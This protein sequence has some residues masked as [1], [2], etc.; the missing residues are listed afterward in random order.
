ME[1]I[2]IAFDGF[3]TA[4]S[5]NELAVAAEQAGAR[6][7]WFAEHMGYREAVVSC[8][9][10]ALAT[11]EA[12]VVP[13]AISPYLWHPTPTAMSLATLAELAAGRV[14][15]ALGTGN[16]LFLK[17]SGKDVEHPV[18]AVSEFL[19]CLRNLWS[20]EPVHFK[21][22]FFTLE[23]ARCAF[24]PPQPIPIYIA[25]IGPK[26]L[27]L[28]GKK[29]DGLAISAGF[30]VPYTKLSLQRLRQGVEAAGR[31]PSEVKT[32][33]YLMT[34]VSDDAAE[35]RAIVREKLAFGLRN[36]YVK[37]NIEYTGID[38]DLAAIA[39]AISRRD[40]VAAAKLVPPEAIDAFT[41]AGTLEDC[42]R[43]LQ[44]YAGLG[45]DEIVIL[46]MGAARHQA[47]ALELIN[48]L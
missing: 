9:A 48:A 16:P 4:P 22:R 29:A 43:R 45:L 28:T 31:R 8:T 41:V 2:G 1:R 15:V 33:T 27:E 47:A 21:G 6:S 18:V 19:D 12:V 7:F 25:A 46:S 40:L 39:A 24:K 26:M 36:K 42:K 17:E 5:A 11:R 10:M 34:C 23:G 44:E 20:G 37:E 14:A 3:M 32:C 30:S 13:T 35:A 38:V